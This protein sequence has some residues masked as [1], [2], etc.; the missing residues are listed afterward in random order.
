MI[1]MYDECYIS[2]ELYF[3]MHTG[4]YVLCRNLST[5]QVHK[6]FLLNK[7]NQTSPDLK[8]GRGRCKLYSGNYAL[9]PPWDQS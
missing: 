1:T 3:H 5:S 6:I 4:M 2:P 8:K 9:W 7:T